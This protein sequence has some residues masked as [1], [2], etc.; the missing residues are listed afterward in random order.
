VSAVPA[1]APAPNTLPQPTDVPWLGLTA[2]LMG[3]FISTLNGRLSSFGLADV[4]GALH[5]GFDDGA[6]ITTAQA[7]AQMLVL[8]FAVWAGSIYGPRMVLIESALAFAIVSFLLPFSPNLPTFLTLQF[9]GGLASG[10]FIPLTLSFILRNMPPWMW[11]YGV[12]TYALNLEL[13]LNIAAS[14]E[15][16]Y[17]EHWSWRWI[18]WQNIPLALLMAL[19]LKL[20]L[21]T[22]SIQ[23]T[24]VK[25]DWFGVLSCGVG[26]ALIYAALDQGNRLD[27][28]NSGLVWGLLL[29]GSVILVAFVVHELT[30]PNPWLQLDVV[31]GRP[32]IFLLVLVSFLRLVILSTSFLIPQYLGQVRG[33]RALEVGDTLIWIALPQ[34]II[35]PLTAIMLRRSDPRIAPT[36]GLCLIGTGCLMV[37]Y[38]LTADWGSDEF[39]ASQLIQAVGQSMGLSGVVFFGVLYLK[40]EQALTFGGMLQIARVMG[41]ELGLAFVT[42]FNRQREQH[43]SNL[44]GQHLERGAADVLHRLQAYATVAGQSGVPNLGG[45]A[46]ILGRVVRSQATT[47]GVADSFLVIALAIPFALSILLL[48]NPPPRGPASHKPLFVRKQGGAP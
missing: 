42:T 33:F 39:L 27:W 11:A 26:L 36:I 3:T 4:R 35:C 32:L 45:G 46:A 16:W 19:C 2:V 41:G 14:L 13:S 40:P 9:I 25:D 6:W 44:I 1:T 5:A 10:C 15:G 8:P 21:R 24:P 28:L 23:L 20:G 31:F 18:F 34:L 38:G 12:A 7:T 29:A 47:Q 43:A 37:A 17:D 30:T 22:A 48:L